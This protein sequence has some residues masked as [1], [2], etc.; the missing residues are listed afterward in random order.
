MAISTLLLS[1][2]LT[3][4][5]WWQP[6]LLLNLFLFGALTIGVLH[7]SFDY[8]VFRLAIK[9]NHR[10]QHILFFLLY[11]A[12]AM[13]IFLLF[14]VQPLLTF[15]LFLFYSAYHF[16]S[17]AEYQLNPLLAMAL[18]ISLITLPTLIYHAEMIDIYKLFLSENDAVHLVSI[19]RYLAVLTSFFIFIYCIKSKNRYVLLSL[20]SALLASPLAFFTAFFCA[21]HSLNYIKQLRM[22]YKRNITKQMLYRGSI[23]FLISLGL[24]VSLSFQYS[25][26]ATH[27]LALFKSF[28]Y[29]IAAISFP[30]L[31]LI[32]YVRR[33]SIIRSKY[34][35]EIIQ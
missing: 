11:S 32:E 10:L 8:D 9:P 16:G 20:F 29:I 25:Q 2:M 14:Q 34:H 21:E 28:I 6:T 13:L 19:S 31:I 23:L 33:L 3:V 5:G 4:L 35:T 12:A 27:H 7:G 15:Y 26:I 22:R 18:G 30:H 24:I 17:A 1:F